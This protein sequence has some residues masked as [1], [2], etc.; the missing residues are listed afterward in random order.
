M[1]NPRVHCRIHKCP[2]PVPILSQLDAVYTPTSHFLK[3]HLNI[4]FSSPKWS[5][6][7]RFSYQ[8]PVYASS[9]SRT[10]YMP[11][12]SHSSRFYHTDNNGEEY[13]LLSSHY[14]VFGRTYILPKL[15]YICGIVQKTTLR[16]I[17]VMCKSSF[18]Y[19]PF[20]RLLFCIM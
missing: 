15:I 14:V 10:H 4:I 8:N 11:R 9:V 16:T 1:W 20:Y 19:F 7:L 6:A 3:I 17:T 13:R 18:L 12:P 5:R 2:E